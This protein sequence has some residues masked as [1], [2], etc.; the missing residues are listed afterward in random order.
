MLTIRKA[1]ERGHANHGWLD[2]FHTFSFAGYY[3]PK[4]MGFRALRVINDDR[5]DGGAGFPTHPHSDMEIITY[6]LDGALQHRDSMGTGSVI[7]R[8]DVQRMSAGTGVTHSEFNA[9]PDQQVHLL[10]I[11]LLPEREDLKPS[12]EEKHFSEDE[13]SN[14]LKL[15]ASR[16]GEAGSIHINQDVRLYASLLAKGKTVEHTIAKGRHAWLQVAR[17]GL[18]VNDLA[19]ATGDGLAVSSEDKLQISA[20]EDSELLLFDLA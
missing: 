3:D 5:V 20:T 2:T 16:G 13:R 18:R 17:G 12:Y 6:I 15:V 8:G 4:H 10:Q 7:K 14:V 19:L 9:S 1:G 11:W